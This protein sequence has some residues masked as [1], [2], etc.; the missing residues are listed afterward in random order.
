MSLN[1]L[2]VLIINNSGVSVSPNNTLL[3][4]CRV[5]LEFYNEDLDLTLLE[6]PY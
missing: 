3:G 6:Q 2:T 4:R 5:E 1:G